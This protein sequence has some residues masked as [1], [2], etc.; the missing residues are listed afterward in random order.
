VRGLLGDDRDGLDAGRAGADHGDP[1]SG[2]VDLFVRPAGGEIGLAG[3]VVDP[4][5]GQLL[6][7]GQAAER[8]DDIFGRDLVALVGGRGPQIRRLVI[9]E[10]GDLGVEVD[11]A[12]Q[13][14]PVGD[15]VEIAEDLL[16]RG[17]ALG[18]G[19]F[20]GQLVV[21]E[22]AIDRR[23]AV[24]ARARIAVPVPGAAHPRAAFDALHR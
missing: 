19:P 12:A 4:G 13:V 9:G 5:D 18:P 20:L 22:V 17:I 24:A 21:E 3:E 15:P 10:R 7:L 6:R 14:E 2:E 16:R 8:G 23:L 11:V 1:L